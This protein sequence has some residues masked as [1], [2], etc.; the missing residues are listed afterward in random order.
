MLAEFLSGLMADV[1]QWEGKSVTW[2]SCARTSSLRCPFDCS[3]RGPSR[4]ALLMHVIAVVNGPRSKK[5]WQYPWAMSAHRQFADA[6]LAHLCPGH[7]SLPRI[8]MA[9]WS[10]PKES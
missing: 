4:R 6:P 8:L 7:L 9:K 1:G 10:Y 5:L 3:W 2:W